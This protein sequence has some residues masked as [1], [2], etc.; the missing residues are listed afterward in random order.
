MSGTASS[1]SVR[2]A[3]GITLGL[4]ENWQQFSLLVL[5]NAFVGGMV[6]LQGT[7]VPLI[8]SQEFKIASTTAVLSFIV[9]FGVIKALANL[10][11]GH[12]AD[13]YG[14]KHMLVLGWLIGLPVPFMIGWGPSWG[15]IIAANALLGINQ[16]FAWS[17]TVIMK[18]DLVGPKSRGLAVGLNEFAGYLSVGLTAFLAGYIAQHYGLAA[19]ALLSRHR[20]R[21]ARA[22]SLHPARAGHP[23]SRWP[24]NHASSCV[25]H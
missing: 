3:A 21:S 24:R 15:W 7:V 13:V 16:G 6:G 2:S 5:I 18:V 23:P 8:G 17:M 10:V 20:L 11:S 25:N 9:S 4:R 19:A 22:H 14:R 1:P 12:F